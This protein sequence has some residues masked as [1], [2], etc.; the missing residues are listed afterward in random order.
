MKAS[1]VCPLSFEELTDTLLLPWDAPLKLTPQV[2]MFEKKDA[3]F[4]LSPSAKAHLKSFNQ[5][6]P[7]K[8]YYDLASNP[9]HRLR[10]ETYDEALM[11]LTTN[12]TIWQLNVRLLFGWWFTT[13]LICLKLINQYAMRST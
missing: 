4:V 13:L 11:T 8:Q 12:S 10:T 9:E 6:A 2:Y 7:S 1:W 5:L 3:D